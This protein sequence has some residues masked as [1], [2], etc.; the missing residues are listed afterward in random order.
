MNRLRAGLKFYRRCLGD[1]WRSSWDMANAWMPIAGLVLLYGGA[2]V[3]GYDIILPGEL[4]QN[5]LAMAI[6]FVAA[7]WVTVFAA[8]LIAAPP[9]LYGELQRTPPAA[10]PAPAPVVALVAPP[11]VA[12]APV[13]VPAVA[14]VLPALDVRLHDQIHETGALDTVGE[15]LPPARAYVARVSNRGDR[16]LRRCH[17][18]FGSPTHIQ[19]VSGPFDLAPGQ[20]RDLPVLRI[21]DQA[22]EPHALAYF[23]DAET[24]QV[25]QGQAAWLFDPGRFKVKVLSDDAP[26]AALEVELSDALTLV[27]V[28]KPECTPRRKR[29]IRTATGRSEAGAMA[30]PELTAGD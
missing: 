6:A 27:A 11:P 13:A 14:P 1:A 20:H 22:D 30:A 3:A 18:F 29:A 25:A 10:I 21:I 26:P 19:V 16:Q 12:A 8:R 24:W 4:D 17:L 7:A 23:L 28:E 2:R 5:P 15:I 9:R